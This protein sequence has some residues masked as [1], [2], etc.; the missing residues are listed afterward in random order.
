M[1]PKIILIIIAFSLVACQN[2]QMNIEPIGYFE[3]NY[4]PSTGAPRQGILEPENSGKIILDK[5]YTGALLELD[6]FEYIIVLYW[7][8]KMETWTP[9]IRPPESH[10]EFGMFATRSPKRPN[11]IGFSVIKLDSIRENIL[12][13]R[14]IDAFNGTPVLDI[15]PY[16]PSID[17]IKSTKNEAVEEELG[18]HDEQF[19]D[20][21]TFWK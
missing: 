21:S 4:R 19:I 1:K 10:H 8:D 6:E 18:H 13:L 2:K 17:A 20:D 14:G 16:L 9:T 3:T 12:Y 11:P 15:K 7:F 5:K